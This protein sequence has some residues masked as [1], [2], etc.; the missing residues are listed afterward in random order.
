MKTTGLPVIVLTLLTLFV[1]GRLRNYKK[2]MVVYH[3]QKVSGE[4]GWKLMAHD[5]LGR[6]HKNF[7]EQRNIWK[8][9]PVFP[10]GMFKTEIHCPFLQSIFAAV[11]RSTELICSNSKREFCDH[12]PKP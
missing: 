12:L 7:R 5:V 6:S 10:E 1:V 3:L 4:S 9:S 2:A 11:F 8:G